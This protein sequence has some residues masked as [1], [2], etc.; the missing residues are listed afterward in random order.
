MAQEDSVQVELLEVVQ[1]CRCAAWA[2]S[3]LGMGSML[4][5]LTSLVEWVLRAGLIP[6]P[7]VGKTSIGA[8][9][10]TRQASLNGG[11]SVMHAVVWWANEV[12]KHWTSVHAALGQGSSHNYCRNCHWATKGGLHYSTSCT[13]KCRMLFVQGWMPHIRY[14]HRSAKRHFRCLYGKIQAAAAAVHKDPMGILPCEN[15]VLLGADNRIIRQGGKR[16]IWSH[17]LKKN[18]R[19]DLSSPGG[20]APYCDY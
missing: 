10:L 3:S 2:P 9:A 20:I 19:G 11:A 8:P 6:Q 18:R 4:N 16:E 14:K 13:W 17:K 5:C 7:S 1:T 15:S 12:E